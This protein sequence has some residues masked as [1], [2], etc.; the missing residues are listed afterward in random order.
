MK[1]IL[2]IG[3]H[4]TGSSS[5]QACLTAARET[6]LDQG[7]LYFAA[8]PLPALS[9]STYYADAQLRDMPGDRRHFRT[10]AEVMKWTTDA[11]ADLETSVASSPARV[12]ILS[13]EQFASLPGERVAEMIGRLRGMFSDIK[14]VA[15]ARDPVSLYLSGLQQNIQGGWRLKAIRT[16]RTFTYLLPR[17]VM[18]YGACVGTEALVVR[19]FTRSHLVGGDVVTDFL[20]VVSGFGH[21]LTVPLRSANEAICGAAVAWLLTVNETWDRGPL[22]AE[23]LRVLNRL[24]RSEALADLPRLKLEDPLLVGALCRGVRRDV[25]WINDTFLKDAPLALSETPPARLP[26]DRHLRERIRDWI[27]SYLTT[28]AMEKIARASLQV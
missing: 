7:A 28:D 19:N 5:I 1:L 24:R 4:K 9:L 21:D 25:D 14:V 10:H 13:S 8:P 12:C 6:L 16:P 11:W 27:M 20:N 17:Q 18:K 2:H 26:E 3:P 23:R 22:G 15:Y